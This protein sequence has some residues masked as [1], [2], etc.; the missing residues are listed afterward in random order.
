MV[1][2]LTHGFT[3]ALGIKFITED[4]SDYESDL[5]EKLTV[6]KYLRL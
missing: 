4:L 3:E 1:A 2:S 5:S 6:E